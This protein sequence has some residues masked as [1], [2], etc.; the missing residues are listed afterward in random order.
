MIGRLTTGSIGL[1]WLAV[2]GRS[3]VPSPPAI[4]TA[5]TA[6]RSPSRVG[7]RSLRC[8]RFSQQLPGLRDIQARGPPVQGTSP[9]NEDPTDDPRH[10]RVA[11]C[12]RTEEE[13][14]KRIEQ[15]QRRG[16]A[17]EADLKRT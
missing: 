14:G 12:V 10:L 5:F 17:G 7:A 6:A 8:S 11:S 13:Q 9:D 16:L 4:T 15:A 1:G 2:I 3:L